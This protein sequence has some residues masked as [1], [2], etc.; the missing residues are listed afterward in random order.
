MAEKLERLEQDVDKL[1]SLAQSGC[2]PV[3][4]RGNKD[5][6]GRQF[7]LP[8]DAEHKATAIRIPSFSG[9]HMRAFHTSWF[10]FWS[11]FL[12]TRVTP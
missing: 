2:C 1:H 6:F 8:V 11:G 9:S 3:N 12:A 7:A 5:I 4:S 10:S